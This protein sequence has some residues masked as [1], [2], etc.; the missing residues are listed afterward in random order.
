MDGLK[1][2]GQQNQTSTGWWFF[3]LPL[4]K[5]MEFVSWDD[6]I[7]SQY[8]GKVII[9]SMV[10]NH[11]A[12]NVTV[13]FL[14]WFPWLFLTWCYLHPWSMEPWDH[15]DV[16]RLKGVVAPVSTPYPSRSLKAIWRPGGTN[17]L[18]VSLTNISTSQHQCFTVSPGEI[19][20]RNAPFKSWKSLVTQRWPWDGLSDRTLT[21]TADFNLMSRSGVSSCRMRL[22]A[23]SEWTFGGPIENSSAMIFSGYTWWNDVKR[24]STWWKTSI[25]SKFHTPQP[26]PEATQPIF[27]K[28]FW[29]GWGQCKLKAKLAIHDELKEPGTAA[30]RLSLSLSCNKHGNKNWMITV[31]HIHTYP[32]LILMGFQ[33]DFK[34]P[35]S[36]C[37]GPMEC[38]IPFE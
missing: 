27:P 7:N 8:D 11:Q 21:S 4:W 6:E 20:F 34:N 36:S 13:F 24:L 3:A 18:E 25:G 38:P 30:G 14:I 12:V 35:P 2:S 26:A 9:H 5:M 15:P 28:V 37:W 32:I 29:G 22:E 17:R 10:P 23:S 19:P 33:W 16:F 31:P 1:R